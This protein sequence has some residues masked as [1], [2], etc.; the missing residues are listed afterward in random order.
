MKW[1]EV[2]LLLLVMGLMFGS[3]HLAIRAMKQLNKGET[4]YA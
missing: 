2:L 4:P 1:W 3:G